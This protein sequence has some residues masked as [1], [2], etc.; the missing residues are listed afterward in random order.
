MSAV[1]VG[2]VVAR[3]VRRSGE[4]RQILKK[5]VRG[6]SCEQ[7]A[8]RGRDPRLLNE[9]VQP[10]G[11]GRDR[12]LE[13]GVEQQEH[14]APVLGRNLAHAKPYV[15]DAAGDSN[16]VFRVDGANRSGNAS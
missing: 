2:R 14:F 3:Q 5:A 15:T 4:L 9:R 6:L 13:R 1:S 8:K 11:A 7:L 10:G 12:Q 16:K